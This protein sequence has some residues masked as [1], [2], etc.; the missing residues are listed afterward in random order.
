MGHVILNNKSKSI[1]DYFAC[2]CMTAGVNVW[3]VKILVQKVM[4]I[5]KSIHYH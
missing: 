3:E 4:N 5:K 1:K 2:G